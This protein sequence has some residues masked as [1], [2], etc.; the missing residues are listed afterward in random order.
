MAITGGTDRLQRNIDGESHIIANLGQPLS[1]IDNIVCLGSGSSVVCSPNTPGIAIGY[2][3]SATDNECIVGS[4]DPLSSVDGSIHT[5]EVKGN[6]TAYGSVAVDTLKAID[7][8]ASGF[9]GL[10]AT[11]N[12]GLSVTSKQMQATASPPI[13]SLPIYIDP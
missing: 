8:P 9:V 5:F 11:F 13:G 2:G 6:N 12:D 4:Y 10:F 7:N 3:A 1:Q